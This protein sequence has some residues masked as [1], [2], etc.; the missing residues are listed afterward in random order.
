MNFSEL[1]RCSLKLSWKKR[2][3]NPCCSPL[4]YRVSCEQDRALPDL[5]AALAR[6]G[7]TKLVYSSSMSLLPAELDEGQRT[8]RNTR[9]RSNPKH[10]CRIF[11]PTLFLVSVH[12]FLPEI[13][14]SVLHTGNFSNHFI[15]KGVNF[16][17]FWFYI[18]NTDHLILATE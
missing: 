18:P 14:A 12:K 7:K 2:Q 9:K 11:W 8:L 13:P 1:H 10:F 3:D 6:T 5:L 17:I 15:T 4:L 16:Q